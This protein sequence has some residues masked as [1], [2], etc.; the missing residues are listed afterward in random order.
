MGDVADACMMGWELIRVSEHCK[1]YNRQLKL[2]DVVYE[3]TSD[4]FAAFF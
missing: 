2:V 1:S 3:E 4:T